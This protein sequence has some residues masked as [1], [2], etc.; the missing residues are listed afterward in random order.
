MNRKQLMVY[1]F[2][3]FYSSYLRRLRPFRWQL[4]VGSG[5]HGKECY[6]LV[7]FKNPQAARHSGFSRW[8]K[9][10]YRRECQAA[11][12]PESSSGSRGGGTAR[13][14]FVFREGNWAF[15]SAGRIWIPV[16]VALSSTVLGPDPAIAKKSEWPCLGLFINKGEVRWCGRFLRSLYLFSVVLPFVAPEAIPTFLR[17]HGV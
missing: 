6:V 9:D 14:G 16:V 1:T 15:I 10:G 13:V 5:C 11:K 4:I 8:E 3:W 7:W 12:R 17:T 2:L